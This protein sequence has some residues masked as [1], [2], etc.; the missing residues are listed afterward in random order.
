MLFVKHAPAIED[1]V[2]SSTDRCCRLV[3]RWSTPKLNKEGIGRA[4]EKEKALF[5]ER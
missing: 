2:G 5:H 3:D 1:L 4:P